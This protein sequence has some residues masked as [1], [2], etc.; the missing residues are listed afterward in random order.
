MLTV[1]QRVLIVYRPPIT[2]N[3]FFNE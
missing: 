3:V 2:A 1:K